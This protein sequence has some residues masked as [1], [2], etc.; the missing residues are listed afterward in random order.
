MYEDSEWSPEDVINAVLGFVEESLICPHCGK[1][2][3]APSGTF[4]T[5]SACGDIWTCEHCDR[6]FTF[7]DIERKEAQG[8]KNDGK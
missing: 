2:V 1:I 6:E 5:V 4:D 7:K 8:D 3:T